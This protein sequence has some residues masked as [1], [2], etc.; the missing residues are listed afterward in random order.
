MNKLWTI[1]SLDLTGMRQSFIIFLLIKKY[2]SQVLQKLPRSLMSWL[3]LMD[4]EEIDEEEIAFNSCLL[5]RE[6][7]LL[8]A[9]D[10]Y[11]QL[12]KLRLM[13][14]KGEEQV[15]NMIFAAIPER[16]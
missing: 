2:G 1:S 9:L 5:P 7:R 8:L 12:K 15:A 6:S 13:P 4:A 10:L 11:M 16:N 14:L 3:H